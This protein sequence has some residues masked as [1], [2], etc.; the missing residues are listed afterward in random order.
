MKSLVIY[1]SATGKTREKAQKLAEEKGA[2]LEEIVPKQAYTDE[3]LDWTNQGSRTSE[4]AK[5]PDLRPEIEEIGESLNAS[6]RV[7]L[8]FPIWWGK[9]PNVVKT[10]LDSYDLSEKELAVFCTSGGSGIST[11]LKDLRSDYPE[12]KIEA[13]GK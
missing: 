3:D 12:L 2:A 10:F 7:Y 5:S 8:G 13:E 4:E 6:G 11:A 9:A 1:F